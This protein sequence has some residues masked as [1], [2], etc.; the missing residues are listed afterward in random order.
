MQIR[1]ADFVLDTRRYLI[2]RSGVPI[3]LRPKVFDLLIHLSANRDRVVT[4]EE[5]VQRL[6]SETIVG[7]GSLSGLVN[8]LRQALGERGDPASTIRTVHARGYQFVAVVHEEAH[9]GRA[10]VTEVAVDVD[11][12]VAECG[13]LASN[14]HPETLIRVRERLHAF[15]WDELCPLVEAEGNRPLSMASLLFLVRD[16]A[17]AD[18]SCDLETGFKANEDDEG[19]ESRPRR[20]LRVTRPPAQAA[21]G[22]A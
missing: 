22:V 1:F 2:T 15:V 12:D 18:P 19:I 13:P 3:A 17:R 10:E 11:V 8:E 5:L 9:P 14:L 6:W 20:T 7:S 21:K 4:R 16:L